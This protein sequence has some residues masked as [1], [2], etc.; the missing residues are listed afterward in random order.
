MFAPQ[1]QT[2]EAWMK[3]S[4]DMF[5]YW[6]EFALEHLDRVRPYWAAR[7]GDREC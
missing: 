1:E 3:P 4:Q 7:K 5:N 2:F 6:I